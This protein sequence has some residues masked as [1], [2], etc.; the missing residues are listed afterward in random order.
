MDA[1]SVR[2]LDAG[3]VRVRTCVDVG[4]H[5]AKSGCFASNRASICYIYLVFFFC[6]DPIPLWPGGLAYLAVRLRGQAEK[7]TDKLLTQSEEDG[8]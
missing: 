1:A 8:A 3:R 4:E 6:G 7:R 2:Q 5:A